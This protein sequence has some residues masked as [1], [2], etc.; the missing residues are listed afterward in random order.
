MKNL[1]IYIIL[2]LTISCDVAKEIIES[3]P[4]AVDAINDIDGNV[5]ICW[6]NEVEYRN[7]GEGWIEASRIVDFTKDCDDFE[8]EEGT[9]EAKVDANG[10]Q[11]QSRI[12]LECES[13]E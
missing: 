1:F 13:S 3:A 2:L 12:D 5:D 8:S 7:F 11:Y 10:V 6:C 4:D 9:P